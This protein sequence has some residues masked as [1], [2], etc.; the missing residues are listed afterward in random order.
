MITIQEL[1]REQNVTY[2]AIRKSVARYKDEL[3][4]HTVKK[5]RKIYLDDEGAD[6]LRSKRRESPLVIIDQNEKDELRAAR[7]E[8][9]MLRA[10]L[11]ESQQKVIQLQERLLSARDAEVKALEDRSKYEHYIA[12]HEETEAKLHTAEEELASTQQELITTKEQLKVVE[13]QV[14]DAKAELEGFKPSWFGFYRKR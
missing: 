7:E 8:A 13:Q 4:G 12:V 2:E 11:L 6:F 3:E 9:D 5:N 1:A 14:T 10:A